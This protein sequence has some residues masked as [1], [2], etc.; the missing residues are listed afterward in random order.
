MYRQ[1]M[2]GKGVMK[3]RSRRKDHLSM[4]G[5]NWFPYRKKEQFNRDL[6]IHSK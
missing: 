5:I 6:I 2:P 4:F 1:L 3:G